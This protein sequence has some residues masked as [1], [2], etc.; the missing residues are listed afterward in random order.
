MKRDLIVCVPIGKV[1]YTEPIDK[2]LLWVQSNTKKVYKNVLF[3]MTISNRVDLNRSSCVYLALNRGSDLLMLDSDVVPLEPFDDV[4]KQVNDD[5]KETKADV[6]LGLIASRLGLLGNNINPTS[7]FSEPTYA[8]LGFTFMPYKTLLKLKPLGFYR[9]PSGDSTPMFFTYTT[10]E[11]EDIEFIRRMRKRGLKIIMDR[12]IKLE[13]Y[14]LFPIKLN[15]M[16][17]EE[18]EVEI[19]GNDGNSSRIT[20]HNDESQQN[21]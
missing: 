5:I 2:I 11:S 8:S 16:M 4:M 10:T 21:Q 14:N 3:K 7:R 1:A 15:P 19:D 6:I 20:M 9:F 18:L 12:S 17:H 13:H